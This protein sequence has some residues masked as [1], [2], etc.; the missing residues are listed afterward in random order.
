MSYAFVVGTC[1]NCG[2]LFSFNPNYVPSYKNIPFCKE[3]MERTNKIRETLG[4]DPFF[5]HPEAYTLE[6]V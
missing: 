6:E 4:N 3:C 5:I 2:R 1:G